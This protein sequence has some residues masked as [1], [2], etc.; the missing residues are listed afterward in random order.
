MRLRL[1]GKRQEDFS[2]VVMVQKPWRGVCSVQIGSESTQ[3]RHRVVTIRLWCVWGGEVLA[4]MH[5]LCG[6]E[7]ALLGLQSLAQP[8]S[9]S[10]GYQTET[11]GRYQS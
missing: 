5:L 2:A 6:E 9:N 4:G 11:L 1:S 10:M 3:R 8:I 7:L